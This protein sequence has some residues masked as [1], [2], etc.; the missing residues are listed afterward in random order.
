MI[1]TFE[2][3]FG[4]IGEEDQS[5]WRGLPNRQGIAHLSMCLLLEIFSTPFAVSC[6]INV[7]RQ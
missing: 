6:Q 2:P 4:F 3:A 5:T 7:R 1:L